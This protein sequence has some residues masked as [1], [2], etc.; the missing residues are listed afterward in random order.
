MLSGGGPRSSVMLAHG[1]VARLD[2]R[3]VQGPILATVPKFRLRGVAAPASGNS[4]IARER[5]L[6]FAAHC[7][8]VRSTCTPRPPGASGPLR[9]GL[10]QWRPLRPVLRARRDAH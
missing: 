7:L 1:A 9:G 4:Y 2:L 3:Q 5:C 6:Q 8:V 10:E